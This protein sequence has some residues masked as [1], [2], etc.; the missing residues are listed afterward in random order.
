M[1]RKQFRD[2]VWFFFSLLETS[3]SSRENCLFSTVNNCTEIDLLWNKTFFYVE[4]LDKIDKIIEP[5]ICSHT[6]Y[7]LGANHV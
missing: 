3:K 5:I 7:A 6:H 4:Y 2:R 1:L